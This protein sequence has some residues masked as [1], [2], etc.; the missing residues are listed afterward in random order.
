MVNHGRIYRGADHPNS[1]LTENDVK[2]ICALAGSMTQREIA[3]TFSVSK[4]A[5]SWILKGETYE[6]V[7]GATDYKRLNTGEDHT[8]AKLTDAQVQE[9]IDKRHDLTQSELAKEFSVSQSHISTIIHGR[10]RNNV[11]NGRAVEYT[12]R[13]QPSGERNGN[14]KLSDEDIDCIW[15]MSETHSQRKIAAML[16]VSQC[17]I[18]NVL[19]GR[20]R[21]GTRH[22]YRRHRAGK[23][24]DDQVEEIRALQGQMLQ[25]EIAERYGIT[26]S[27][28]SN[29]HREKSRAS[30]SQC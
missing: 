4:S 17:Q 24:T 30:Q 3:K 8:S 5:V 14:A 10:V 6:G 27:Q 15:E 28:V 2:E 23:L 9:I 26:Q 29:I 22:E 11:T 16:G 19:S 20:Q 7:S 1:K 13:P 12:P 21:G 18:Y 25:R